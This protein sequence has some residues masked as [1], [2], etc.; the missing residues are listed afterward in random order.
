MFQRKLLF[1]VVIVGDSGVGKSTM[2]QRLITGRFLPQKTTIGTDLA[3]YYFEINKTKINLQLWDFAG[4]KKFRFFLP[5]YCRGA[6]GCL[7]CYDLTR[8]ASFENLKEWYDIVVNNAKNPVFVL[9]GGKSDLTEDLRAVEPE[10]A[11]KYKSKYNITHF[12]ETSSKTGINNKLI[13]E[14]LALTIIEKN[15]IQV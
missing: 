15:K 2:V 6:Q 8:Y 13:F 9:V 12:F 14:T 11:E 10:Q 5:N 7:L 3:S 4:E 1:K